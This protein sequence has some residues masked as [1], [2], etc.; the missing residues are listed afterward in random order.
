MSP[1]RGCEAT[2]TR[3]VSD[4][5]VSTKIALKRIRSEMS[6]NGNNG[7]FPSMSLN[8]AMGNP[9]AFASGSQFGRTQP[10]AER[11]TFQVTFPVAGNSANKHPGQQQ[12]QQPRFAGETSGRRSFFSGISSALQHSSTPNMS[13][14]C[15]LYHQGSRGGDQLE[16]VS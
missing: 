10:P 1:K 14:Y 12:Q 11:T 8:P 3:T 7:R 16:C 9:S 15:K 2:V 5:F 13:S 6:T 4:L